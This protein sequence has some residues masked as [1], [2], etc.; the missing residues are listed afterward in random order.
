MPQIGVR[1]TAAIHWSSFCQ[2]L[3]TSSKEKSQ[4]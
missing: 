4:P 2:M 3:C 1:A